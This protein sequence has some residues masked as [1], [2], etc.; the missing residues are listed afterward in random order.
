MPVDMSMAP[1]ELTAV[2]VAKALADPTRFRLLRAIARRD[3]VSCQQLTSLF[4]VG[5]PTVS[6]HL[7]VLAGA[8][9]VS[10]RKEGPFHY[11][12]LHREALAEHGA[13]IAAA[14]A[15]ARRVRRAR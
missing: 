13:A 10:A 6:H 2:R 9:L 11:Y 1:R 5:Q 12:R 8:G 15:P 4:H 3:E 7:K 14:F